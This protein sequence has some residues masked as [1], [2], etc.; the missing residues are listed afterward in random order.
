MTLKE[1]ALN[2]TA[3]QLQIVV[4]MNRHHITFEDDEELWKAV[5]QDNG[6]AN[7]KVVYFTIENSQLNIRVF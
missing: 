4:M 5:E 3:C 1:F 7:T 2:L 6:L